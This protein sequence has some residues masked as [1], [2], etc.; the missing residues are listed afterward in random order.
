M[1]DMYAMLNMLKKVKNIFP[2]Q[3]VHGMWGG[4]LFIQGICLCIALGAVI[5]W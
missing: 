1:F 3:I 2:A 5:Y 4:G